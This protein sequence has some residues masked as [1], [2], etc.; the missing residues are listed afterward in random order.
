[1]PEDGTETQN[2]VLVIPIVIRHVP[3]RE[4]YSAALS[5][6]WTTRQKFSSPPNSLNPLPPEF[7]FLAVFRDIA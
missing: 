6:I 3:H 7:L 5:D 4:D 2:V 1:M